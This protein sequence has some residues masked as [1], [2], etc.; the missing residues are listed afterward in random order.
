MRPLKAKRVRDGVLRI[1]MIY[2]VTVDEEFLRTNPA[3]Q[4]QIIKRDLLQSAHDVIEDTDFGQVEI[5][6]EA[7]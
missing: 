5:V 4:K 7:R 1:E 2:G 6:E 3:A